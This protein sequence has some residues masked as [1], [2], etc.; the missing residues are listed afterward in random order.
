LKKKINKNVGFTCSYS[1][2]H[3]CS[4]WCD[5]IHCLQKAWYNNSER[6]LI[7]WI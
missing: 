3:V 5:S 2:L 6:D 4:C 1:V 7:L